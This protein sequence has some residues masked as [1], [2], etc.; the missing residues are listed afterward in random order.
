MTL[1]TIMPPPTCDNYKAK[2]AF[3]GIFDPTITLT[4]D[5][6]TPK[7]ELSIS[8]SKSSYFYEVA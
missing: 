6:L 5:L 4:L 2:N 3:R 7:F 1:P 8:A